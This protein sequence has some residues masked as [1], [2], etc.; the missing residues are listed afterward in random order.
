MIDNK[1]K[2]ESNTAGS[3][4]ASHVFDTVKENFVRAVDEMAKVQPQYAQAFSNLQLD[5]IQTAKNSINNKQ[6]K[7]KHNNKQRDKEK[8]KKKKHKH[9][10]KG[11]NKKKEHAKQKRN[12]RRQERERR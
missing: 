4:S 3:S 7:T 12:R 9:R 1:S 5:Y 6:N 2:D 11:K 10:K 8:E